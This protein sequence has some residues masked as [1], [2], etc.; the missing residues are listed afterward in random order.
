MSIFVNINYIENLAHTPTNKLS[1]VPFRSFLNALEETFA[2]DAKT[3]TARKNIQNRITNAVAD[4][5]ANNKFSG[6]AAFR[7][8]ML[9]G[10]AGGTIHPDDQVYV[11]EYVRRVIDPKGSA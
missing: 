7:E 9:K 11:A 2:R 6:S 3:T 5:I 10:V 1:P 8:R 4:I